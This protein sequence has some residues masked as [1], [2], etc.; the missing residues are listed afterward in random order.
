MKYFTTQLLMLLVLSLQ[1]SKV[2]AT[3]EDD[4]LLLIPSIVAN[5][6]E[7]GTPPADSLAK[8]KLLAG[9]WYFNQDLFSGEFRFYASTAEVDATD[10][11]IATIEGT[12]FLGDFDFEYAPL[13]ALYI[14]SEKSYLAV[15]FWGPPTNDSASYYFFSSASKN[16]S[17]DCHY[18]GDTSG[19]IRSYYIGFGGS[20]PCDTFTK[21]KASNIGAK[22]G[23]ST[24]ATTSDK[25]AL[26]TKRLEL[27]VSDD[28]TNRKE[29]MLL[30]KSYNSPTMNKKIK[31]KILLMTQAVER[32]KR[33]R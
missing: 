17:T 30:T 12:S 24:G 14:E 25:L 22:V 33:R 8:I 6:H 19:N 1:I 11:D 7:V 2:S 27:L 4:L 26:K 9:S 32:S 15:E 10:N 21:I 3:D 23:D 20:I 13:L 29:E 16:T 31:R 18:Y 28:L 5:N